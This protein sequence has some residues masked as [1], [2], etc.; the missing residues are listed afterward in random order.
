[1][2]AFRS[3][4]NHPAYWEKRLESGIYRSRP[5]DVLHQVYED[6][7]VV[8]IIIDADYRTVFALASCSGLVEY[9]SKHVQT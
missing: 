8:G 3:K 9:Y 4:A 2:M 7:G 5:I 6:A 1:M